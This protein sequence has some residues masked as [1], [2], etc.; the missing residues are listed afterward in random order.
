MVQLLGSDRHED[1]RNFVDD[2]DRIRAGETLKTVESV[3]P[4][5]S[6][7]KPIEQNVSTNSANVPSKKAP[8][9]SKNNSNSKANGMVTGKQQ[10]SYAS[11]VPT[12]SNV[13]KNVQKPKKT[14]QARKSDQKI[15]N[16]TAKV[17][18]E[19]RQHQ[20]QQEVL[21]LQGKAKVVCGCF[22]TMHKALN[23]CLHCGRIS[24]EREGYDYCPFC[25][26]MVYEHR[27]NV[28]SQSTASATI[29]TNEA[30]EQKERLLQYDREFAQRTIIL[31]DQADYYNRTTSNWL[32]EQEQQEA[33][34]LE[35]E[36]T[37]AIQTRPRPIMKLDL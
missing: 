37:N 1:L 22:G 17:V 14:E 35:Q 19:E 36:R 21:P 30:W 10:K 32:N 24:C 3:V 9:A 5:N 20:R 4:S 12:I 11:I 16:E 25:S 23:N 6:S 34:Q 26:Y 8:P 7:M 27:S 28:I 29:S 13:Q 2:V 31:D 33:Q 18:K 15:S